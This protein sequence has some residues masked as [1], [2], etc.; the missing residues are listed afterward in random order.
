MRATRSLSGCI[1]LISVILI[2]K[3]PLLSFD[4]RPAMASILVGNTTSPRQSLWQV[5]PYLRRLVPGLP[6]PV[7]STNAFRREAPLGW[8]VTA[9]CY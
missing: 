7:R 8:V 3:Y 5:G 4:L 1:Y 6:I 2:S 9:T